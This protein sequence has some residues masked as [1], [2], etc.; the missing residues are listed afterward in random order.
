MEVVLDTCSQT[1]ITSSDDSHAVISIKVEQEEVPQPISFPLIK[2]EPEE[3]SYLCVPTVR[4]VSY[5]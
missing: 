3:V 2:S 1:S 5:L 4:H